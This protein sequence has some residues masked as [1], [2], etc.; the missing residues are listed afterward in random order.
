MDF[1]TE[2]ATRVPQRMF[3]RLFEL[4]RKN[5]FHQRNFVGLLFRTARSPAGPDDGGIDAPQTAAQS[6]AALE[7]FQQRR[8]HLGPSAVPAPAAEAPVDGLPRAIVFG[9]VAPGCPRVESP[10]DTVKDA[11]MILPRPPP[12]V[13]M[14]RVGEERCNALPVRRRDI[15]ASLNRRPP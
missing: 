13:L 12:L 1:G 14:G 10:E 15:M 2:A 9:D 8:E 5:P 11:L 7:V 6:A 4:R 3:R